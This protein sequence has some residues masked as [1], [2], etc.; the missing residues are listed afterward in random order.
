LTSFSE[1][2]FTVWYISFVYILF[3]ALQNYTDYYLQKCSFLS[4]DGRFDRRHVLWWQW[5]ICEMCDSKSR[6]SCIFSR[7]W[8]EGTGKMISR[9][10]FYMQP[11][12]LWSIDEARHARQSFWDGIQL[13][14]S[15][16]KESGS[17]NSCCQWACCS[18]RLSTCCRLWYCDLHR[19][20]LVFNPRVGV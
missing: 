6:G 13:D 20:K 3:F 10:V 11:I 17:N 14:G 15:A 16:Q 5:S 8:F 1:N 19:K 2:N 4:N 12:I 9:W 7:S 18:F